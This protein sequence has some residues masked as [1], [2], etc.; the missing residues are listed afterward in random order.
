[1]LYNKIL[2]TGGAGYVG[3]MLVSRLLF[4]GYRVR[5]LDIYFFGYRSLSHIRGHLRFEE[6]KGDLRDKLVLSKAIIGAD[7][8]IHLACISNDPSFDI[9]PSFGKSINYDAFFAFLSALKGANIKLIIYASSSSV[10]GIKYST[11]INEKCNPE[12]LTDYSR[13]KFYCEKLLL[14][15]PDDCLDVVIVRSATVCGYSPRMRFDIVPNLFINQV[16]TYGELLVYGGNQ[17]R[18]F[19]DI[20]DIVDLYIYL[21]ET[22]VSHISKLIFNAGFDNFSILSLAKTIKD[23]TLHSYINIHFT[24]TSDNRSYHIS[25]KKLTSLLNW[26][27]TKTLAQAIINLMNRYD[28]SIFVN[29]DKDNIYYNVK[30]L[31]IMI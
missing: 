19:I 10:Y 2:V 1:M 21:L 14:S 4:I 6:I 22:P 7:V 5:S 3:S 27:T 16:Y 31:S 24:Y 23:L 11:A 9:D 18:P 25:S 29:T 20:D 30:R 12:P 13:F 8:I 26:S 15:Y 17:L 28:K